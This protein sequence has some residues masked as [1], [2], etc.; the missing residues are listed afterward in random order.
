MP[1]PIL[2]LSNGIKLIHK[3][4]DSPVSHFGVLVNAG[5]RDELVSGSGLA[6]FVE[7]TIFKGTEKRSSNQVIRRI[8]DVGGDLNASTSK[9]ETY[10]HA[11]FLS[12]YYKRVIELLA[13]IFFN[14]TFPEKEI[15]KE[16][17]VV[18]EEINYYHDTPSELIFDE[19]ESLVFADHPLGR[20]ILGEKKRV[21]AIK[22]T[23]I[24]D[25]IQ[26]HY[27]LPHIVLSSAGNISAEALFNLCNRYFGNVSMLE[28]T[29]Q[30]SPFTEY[31]PQWKTVHKQ[32]S[33][34]HIAIAN[35]AYSFLEDKKN[36]FMLLTN[37]LGGPGMNTRLNIAIRENRGLAYS[38]DASYASF[39]DTGLFVV[40]IGC[41]KENTEKCV[42]L[43]YKEMRK[44][45]QQKLGTQQLQNIKNQFLG[46]MAIANESKLT[47]MLTLGRTALYFDEV[48]T[49]EESIENINGI[50]ADELLEVANEIL[51][52]EAMT[53]LLY[54]K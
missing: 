12:D 9:E 38:V 20:N 46:Q 10:F 47:E 15:E 16:K 53:V 27:A 13:D 51:Q 23:D 50:T 6:H 33:Q 1:H 18:I 7:H 30:R 8:E 42:E 17:N 24:L 11:S 34:T 40:Y 25:F 43:T 5:T 31:R 39:S 4:I 52:P 3:Q 49:L 26:E 32:T 35:P 36:P 44:L 14:A 45:C 28:A 21:K 41:D 29:Q 54:Q 2:Y 37:M 19:I 22:R 48:E